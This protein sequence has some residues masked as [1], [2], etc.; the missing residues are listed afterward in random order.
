MALYAQDFGMPSRRQLY[1]HRCVR[2]LQ[3]FVVEESLRT[4]IDSGLGS[5]YQVWLCAAE[6]ENHPMPILKPRS[7]QA[8]GGTG[9]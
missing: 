6:F 8:R 3:P 7:L 2:V 5:W 9:S 1:V 4:V